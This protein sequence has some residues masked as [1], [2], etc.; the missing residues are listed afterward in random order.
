[1]W[2]TRMR[3]Q[4]L[5]LLL[6]VTQGLA[7]QLWAIARTWPVPMP[8]HSNS[9]VLPT[10]FSTS[11][12]QDMPCTIPTQEA[13]ANYTATN[14]TLAGTL[15]FTLNRSVAPCIFL[16]SRYLVNW[17]DPIDIGGTS[18]RVL[19]E[20][21]SKLSSG[22]GQGSGEMGTNSSSSLNITTLL[23]SQYLIIPSDGNS[24]QD[25]STKR[26]VLP[27]CLPYQDFPPDFSPCQS[28]GHRNTQISSGF[29]F[30]PPL[31]KAK[32]TNNSRIATRP[33][34]IWPWYQWLLSNN[35]AAFTSLTPFSRL[36]GGNFSL[37]NI[38]A[39]R[40]P[41]MSLTDI[42]INGQLRNLSYTGAPVCMKPPF[43]FI[44]INTSEEVLSC[45]ASGV[46]C[47][48]S[49]CWDGTSTTA[50]VVRLPT[51]VPIPVEADPEQ[52]PV[53][54]LLRHK[55]DFGITAAIVAAIVTSA[56]SATTAAVAMAS[57]V[58]TA[59]TVNSIVE[60]TAAALTTQREINAHLT[61][62]I[63][64]ANQSIDIVQ[65][66]VEELFRVIQA[67][68]VYSM[69]G[70]CV[71]PLQA[72]VSQSVNQ[73]RVLSEYLRGNWSLQAEEMV[74]RL[75][76][77]VAQLNGTRLQPLSLNDLT[78]WIAKAFSFFKEWVGVFIW[79]AVVLAD[80]IFCMCLLYKLKRDH[81]RHKTVVY[82]AL[83]AIEDGEPP[84]VWLATLKEL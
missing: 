43:F 40:H 30:S 13:P 14:Y 58:Q 6:L 16:A 56:A 81:A 64:L 55:R 19:H 44:L 10:F 21:L 12:E 66:Q 59:E 75:F 17:L 78:S 47:L 27:I 50:L 8:I 84:H 74:T 29:E 38:S 11:C 57:Q 33:G 77:Q 48:M 54:S 2:G 83:A 60:Q 65:H 41:N 35:K 31:F 23:M 67:S 1:M 82:Q 49:E 15:C 53:L 80:C 42:K 9:P 26:K 51:F 69:R 3:I 45:N 72:N 37:V 46:A 28:P 34:N 25:N 63:L 5:S 7:I 76:V 61:S 22:S 18:T 52:F 73:S 79:G 36:R 4:M 71:T 20:A 32:Y 68:C 39:T 24:T 70:L 62:G